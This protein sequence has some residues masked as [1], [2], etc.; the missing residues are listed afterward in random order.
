MANTKSTVSI[1]T[2]TYFGDHFYY[3]G[4]ALLILGIPVLIIKWNVGLIF[5]LVGLLVTT[6][7]YKLVIDP[8]QNKIEDFLFFL[9]RKQ[10]K[11]AKNYTSL[12]HIAI[13]SGR[14]SQQLQLRAASTIIEGT[15]YSAYLITDEE[16]FYL[17]ESK[18]KKR[19]STKGRRIAEKLGI[20]VEELNL[21][22]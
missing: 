12:K 18:S 21:E 7:S 22:E 19:I 15:M 11:I 16:N 5:L 9:G 4:W 6:T 10:G 14:Y 3:T 1:T 2:Q 8:A 13:K 17:G 20:K